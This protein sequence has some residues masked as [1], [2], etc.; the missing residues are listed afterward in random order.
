MKLIETPST[1]QAASSAS[2][3][4]TKTDTSSAPL[5]LMPSYMF[6]VKLGSL[7]VAMFTECSGLGAK[8]AFEP[9]KEGGVNDHVHILPGTIEH[10]NITLKRGISLSTALWDWFQ[11]GQFDF[12]VSRQDITIYQFSPETDTGTE[13]ATAIKT[14]SLSKAFPVS[15]KL[16][17]MTSSNSGLV[18]ETLEIAHDGL[19]LI[20][21]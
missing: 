1:A 17:E 6:S 2:T 12:A 21:S 11:A 5:V 10:S 4:T 16:G 13:Q 15:W 7:Q 19:S 20:S 8:R 9:V 3:S 14:W 18:I